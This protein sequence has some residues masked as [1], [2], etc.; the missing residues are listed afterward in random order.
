MSFDVGRIHKSTRRI[1]KFLHNNSKRPSSDAVHNLRTSTRSLETTLVTLGLDRKGKT[2]RLLRELADIRKRAGKVR[3]MDVL[4]AHIL[5]IKPD[6]EQD[7]LVQLLEYLGA[8]RRSDAG[9]LRDAIDKSRA[10]IRR[11]LKASM[12]RIEKLLD[13][14]KNSPQDSD[15]VSATIAKAIQLSSELNSPTRLTRGN[16]HPFR[17]K[18]KEL[19]DVLQLSDHADHQEFVATLGEVKDAIG[20]WHDWEELVGIADG[21][22]DHPSCKLMKKLRGVAN[23]RYERALVLTKN[24]R[25]HYLKSAKAKRGKPRAGTAVLS[26]TVLKATSSI[27]DH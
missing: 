25:T 8:E 12:N 20:E 14:A 9:K 7:C 18:V 16:L 26:A 13:R 27:A 11:G 21:L 10:R 19:R 4:T 23:S 1:L 5:T 24:L 6:G 2:S 17:L 15:A 3:D 22:L